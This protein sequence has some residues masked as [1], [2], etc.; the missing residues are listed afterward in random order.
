[1]SSPSL[2]RVAV[3]EFIG[4]VLRGQGVAPSLV[5]VDEVGCPGEAHSPKHRRCEA[6]AVALVADENDPSVVAGV[7]DPIWAGGVEA[8]FEDVAVDRDGTGERSIS[9][10]LF[11]G[12]DVDDQSPRRLFGCDL[13]RWHTVETGPGVGEQLRDRPG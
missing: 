9:A 8:P 4:F 3:T 1:M 13:V 7:G 6:R 2:P 5:S 12:P 10:A 11:E